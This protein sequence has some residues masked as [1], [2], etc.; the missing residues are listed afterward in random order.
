M[1]YIAESCVELTAQL[2]QRTKSTSNIECSGALSCK[3]AN[4]YTVADNSEAYIHCEGTI[5]FN[6][7]KVRIQKPVF[8][9]LYAYMCV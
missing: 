1:T 9:Y 4:V 7:F 5:N 6:L 8:E 2:G 3:M